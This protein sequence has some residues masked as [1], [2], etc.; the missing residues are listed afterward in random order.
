MVN[1]NET[2]FYNS[3]CQTPSISISCAFVQRV[4][5]NGWTILDTNQSPSC[6]TLRQRPGT[7]REALLAGVGHDVGRGGHDP[8]RRQPRKA[9]LPLY[10]A[11]VPHTLEAVHHRHVERPS[12]VTNNV[13]RRVTEGKGRDSNETRERRIEGNAGLREQWNEGTSKT[14]E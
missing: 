10:A 12:T 9:A 7:G 2:I 1:W 6:S 4:K 8:D 13:V 14:R 3:I 11:H 5:A